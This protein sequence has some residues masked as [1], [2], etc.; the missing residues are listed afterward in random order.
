MREEGKV[1]KETFIYRRNKK[2][3]V[4]Q[5]NYYPNLSY[6]TK[7]DGVTSKIYFFPR[8]FHFENKKKHAK[9]LI[10]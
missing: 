1:R 8:E 2:E 9:N 5:K 4:N 3:T 7:D 10:K 6:R